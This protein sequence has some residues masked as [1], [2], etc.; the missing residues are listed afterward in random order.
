MK[1]KIGI[2][3]SGTAGLQL[4][5]ALKE[6]FDVTIIERRTSDQIK[7]GRIM[8]SQVH[9]GSTK[10]RENRFQ[11]P[12]WETSNRLECVNVLMGDQKLF[13]GYLEKFGQS[14]DQR[15]Y[16]SDCMKDL[17]E[18]GV[19]FQT[20][21][22]DESKKQLLVESFDL[23]IDCTGKKGPLFPFPV[24]K[25]LSP[26][27]APPRKQ[28]TGYFFGISP[29][30]RPGLCMTVLPDEGELFEAPGVTEYG[31]VTIIYLSIIPGRQLD[32]FTGIKTANDFTHQIKNILETYF[33]ATYNRIDLDT[34]SLCDEQ[35]FMQIAYIPI[36]RKPYLMVEDTLVLGCGDSV[37]L[38]D[39]I[40]GQGSN[41]ASYC[42]EQLADLLLEKKDVSWNH[43]IGEDYWQ[44][45][46]Y[47]V[48]AVTRWTNA[49][50]SPLP[51]HVLQLLFECSQD[52]TKANE[53]AKWF[54]DPTIPYH[55]FFPSDQV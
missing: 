2:I 14:V 4:A 55:I 8:S 53:F 44:R 29:F 1:K 50:T 35:G 20:G 12:K 37:S 49:M 6:D 39:P 43:G 52:Q 40:T 26:F 31:P 22:I 7:N 17:E 16:Y 32:V 11:M 47:R 3:G 23:L 15:L 41:L 36:I 18:K 25:D 48:E 27:H 45:V 33:P 42:A 54:D 24:I 30:D 21:K 13:T 10:A 51:E 19:S 28:V 46:Q 9:S 38:N 5:Y 34:F